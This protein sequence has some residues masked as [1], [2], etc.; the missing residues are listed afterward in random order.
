MES[1]YPSTGQLL[2]HA[3]DQLAMGQYFGFENRSL[4]MLA[5]PF[6]AKW[7]R[8]VRSVAFLCSD[9]L[10]CRRADYPYQKVETFPLLGLVAASFVTV[11]VSKIP[12]ASYWLDCSLRFKPKDFA[13]AW[14]YTFVQSVRPS[15][16]RF[17]LIIEF[18]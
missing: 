2:K 12:L 11:R 9:L 1:I 16:N 8:A 15:T 18:L 17:I 4:L 13:R 7:Q 6:T 3:C 5:C 14:L 10:C